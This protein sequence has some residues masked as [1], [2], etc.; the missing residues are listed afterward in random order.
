MLDPLELELR[1][2]VSRCVGAEHGTQ[3]LYKKSM[4]SSPLRHLSSP[5]GMC[6]KAKPTVGGVIPWAGGSGLH[7]EAEQAMENKAV[8]GGS[9]AVSASAAA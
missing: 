3:V 6:G 1:I 2:G 9:S 4:P 5:C 8:N 7:S